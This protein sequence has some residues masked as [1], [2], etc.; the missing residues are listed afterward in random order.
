MGAD[1]GGRHVQGEGKDEEGRRQADREAVGDGHREQIAD[2]RSDHQRRKHDEECK[3]G[4]CG[5]PGGAF[6]AQPPVSSPGPINPFLNIP[7]PD[8][9][10]PKTGPLSD[11]HVD[12]GRIRGDNRRI[13]LAEA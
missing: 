4:H 9:K 8:Q 2:R 7:R 12:R 6:A 3:I 11:S 5:I 1:R 13:L 10:S